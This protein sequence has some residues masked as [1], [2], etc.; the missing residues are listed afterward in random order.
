[1]NWRKLFMK[2]KAKKTS[3][4]VLDSW[5]E[6]FALH[7][8]NES[9][10]LVEEIG[11]PKGAEKQLASKFMQYYVEKMI[12]NAFKDVEGKKMNQIE[13]FELAKNNYLAVKQEIQE[14]VARGFERAFKNFLGQ[15]VEYYCQIKLVP[16]VANKEMN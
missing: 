11:K 4:M 7:I 2:T 12:V 10:K 14:E 1:M 6:E 15:S 13:V 8:A 16:E 9:I 5:V 3:N